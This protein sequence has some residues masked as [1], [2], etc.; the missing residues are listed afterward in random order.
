M[1]IG[2]L[3]KLY[4][5]TGAL[6]FA[7][8]ADTFMNDYPRPA[9]ARQPAG[10]ARHVPGR[11][12]ERGR[13]RDRP[14]HRHGE[15]RDHVA[16]PPRA[17]VCGRGR[18]SASARTPAPSAA[19][20]CRS[21][22]AGS[23]CSASPRS[24]RT[25]RRASSTVAARSDAGGAQVRPAGA[26]DRPAARRLGRRADAEGGRCARSST[27]TARVC[28]SE[29]ELAGY[30]IQLRVGRAAVLSAARGLTRRARRGGRAAQRPGAGEAESLGEG[31]GVGAGC[32]SS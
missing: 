25:R 1:H 20:G 27:A 32:M 11:A 14:P 28:V 5:M 10:P 17:S 9:R 6:V 23:C 29:G 7:R 22:P 26:R 3:L 24:T 30:W 16:R 31:D 19:G 18:R 12:G 15:A 8:A 13:R 2:Q 4:H 21:A